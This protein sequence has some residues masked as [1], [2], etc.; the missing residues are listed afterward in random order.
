MY[1]LLLVDDEAII[2]EGI[3]KMIDWVRLGIR[4]TASCANAIAALDSM[5]DDMPDILVTDVRMPGMD[6]LELVERARRLHPQLRCIIL[7]GYDE[8]DYARKALQFGVI[9]YLLKPCSQEEIESALNR[10]C[11]DVERLRQRSTCLYGE[12]RERIATL[13]QRME[14]L[15]H[16]Q[17]DAS[18]LEKQ[19]HELARTAEDASMLREALFSLVTDT[20]GGA[21]AD[22][23]VSLVQEALHGDDA[24]EMLTV[25]ALIRLRGE[26]GGYQRSF[27]QQMV[28]YVG[29]HYMDEALS[30]QF[31]ADNVVYMNADYI[32]R[33]FARSMGQKFSSF[34]MEVRMEHAKGLMLSSVDMH[35]YEI[36]ERVGLGNNPHYFS[37]LFR[38]YTGMTPRDFRT[39]YV[40]KA[41]K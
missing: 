21:Q 8:F 1:K 33:E 14:A 37:Q 2:R 15:V 23:V 22:W 6:G 30:L 40:K 39:K 25:R 19:V 31:M 16:T 4:L 27:V 32:G 36:A 24:L 18:T 17:G 26:S 11:Q 5:M 12:R 29:E 3:E 13:R 38:K 35:S 10:A 41:E 28:D 20:V 7:S 34:L 9:E